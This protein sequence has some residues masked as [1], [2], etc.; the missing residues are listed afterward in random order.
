[1]KHRTIILLFFFIIFL[2]SCSGDG[3]KDKIIFRVT[4]ESEPDSLDPQL[5][6][7]VQ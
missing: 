2:I 1:M 7:S 4:N 6:T 5:A 3:Y